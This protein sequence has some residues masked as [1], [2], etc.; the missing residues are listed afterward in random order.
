MI[1][2]SENS[3]I[4]NSLIATQWSLQ[5]FKSYLHYADLPQAE[6]LWKRGLAHPVLSVTMC[7]VTGDGLDEIIILSTAGVHILQVSVILYSG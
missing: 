3:L 4:T 1:L 6:L 7:D 2:V 5:L